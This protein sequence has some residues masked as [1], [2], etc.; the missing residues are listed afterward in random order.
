MFRRKFDTTHIQSKGH[1]KTQEDD[2]LHAKE[3]GLGQILLLQPSEETNP[4]DILNLDFQ[5]L[6]L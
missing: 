4:A 2:H 5:P 1:V 6:E 3:R